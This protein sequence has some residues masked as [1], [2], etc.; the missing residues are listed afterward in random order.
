MISQKKLLDNGH[1]EFF[2][3]FLRHP[4]MIGS[5][6]PS[7]RF[8][9]QRVVRA[10]G[11]AR[12]RHVVELG[13]GTG[14]TTRA[15]LKALPKRSRLLA[16]ELNADFVCHLNANPDPRLN[17]CQASAEHIRGA[18]EALR[19]GKPDAVVSGIPF[20]TIPSGVGKRILREIWACLAPGG[21]FV[22][23]QVKKQVALLEPQLFGAP[24]VE[25]EFLNVP[26][27]RVF[28]WRKPLH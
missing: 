15:I 8:L 10:A 26:P 19:F 13:P 5:V 22:A 17:V 7:S 24:E 28:S 25:V 16:I 4:S 21:K 3:G 2:R 14:G 9:E 6:I 23:Y 20:S 1:I 27:L 18:L 11:I 12:C